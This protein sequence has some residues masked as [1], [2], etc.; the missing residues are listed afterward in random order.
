LLHLFLQQNSF[1]LLDLAL[2][3]LDLLLLLRQQLLPL[4]LRR[5][6]LMPNIGARVDMS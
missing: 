2:P 3:L 6:G 1:L 4:L 5:L